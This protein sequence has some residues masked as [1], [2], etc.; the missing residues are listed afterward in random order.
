MSCDHCVAC[1]KVSGSDIVA[2]PNYSSPRRT[3]KLECELNHTTLR[4]QSD[5]ALSYSWDNLKLVRADTV[6]GKSIRMTGNLFAALQRLKLHDQGRV[7]RIDAICI[8]QRDNDERAGQLQRMRDIYRGAKRLIIWLVKATV[9]VEL[10][11]QRLRK[12]EKQDP[13]PHLTGTTE[14]DWSLHQV[15]RTLLQKIWLSRVWIL[16]KVADARVADICAGKHSACSSRT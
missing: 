13:G 7:L 8:N 1:Q 12:T 16:Q 2:L 3:A 4:S 14:R 5:E 6:N 10:L 9:E 11:M 15:L